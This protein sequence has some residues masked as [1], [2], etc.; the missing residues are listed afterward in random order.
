LIK[1]ITGIRPSIIESGSVD[2]KK[3]AIRF[4]L[5]GDSKL[6][7]D[8]Y[9][10]ATGNTGITITANEPCGLLYGAY[11][12]LEEVGC[13]FVYLG[14]Q[15]EVVPQLASLEFCRGERIFNPILEHRGLAPYGLQTECWS[16]YILNLPKTNKHHCAVGTFYNPTHSAA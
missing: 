2:Q 1:L 14:K 16:C 8:G 15:E 11:Q 6:T 7:W 9:R 13:S 4:S 3:I 10:I 5:D 12:L